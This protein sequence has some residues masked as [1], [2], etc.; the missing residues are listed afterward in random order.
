MDADPFV[1]EPRERYRAVS[2]FFT[3]VSLS[4]EGKPLPVPQLLV[5]AFLSGLDP[6]GPSFLLLLLGWSPAQEILFP[7][8]TQQKNMS[9]NKTS[10]ERLQGFCFC[11]V[12]FYFCFV[13]FCFGILVLFWFL[14]VFILFCFLFILKIVWRLGIFSFLIVEDRLHACPAPGDP[15]WQPPHP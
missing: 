11:C 13:C 6:A 12:L 1:D 9:T 3:Y 4:K 8:V 7:G 10:Q 15:E 14:F 2:A 5:R